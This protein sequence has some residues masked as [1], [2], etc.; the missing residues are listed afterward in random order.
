MKRLALIASALLLGAC[1]GSA[2]PATYSGA[3]Q[4]T[5]PDE[6]EPT[7]IEEAEAQV[8]RARAQLDSAPHSATSAAPSAERSVATDSAGYRTHEPEECRAL[9]SLER[10][11]AALCRLAGADDPRCKEATQA[12]EQS[13]ARVHCP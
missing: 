12:L 5:A 7:T 8:Q 2:S 13:R 3:P 1:G 10:A 6:P 9:H 11:S 4:T